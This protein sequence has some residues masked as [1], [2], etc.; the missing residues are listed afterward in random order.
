MITS[1]SKPTPDGDAPAIQMNED[2][3]VICTDSDPTLHR[4][5]TFSH[6]GTTQAPAITNSG[7]SF[8]SSMSVPGSLP[9]ASLRQQEHRRPRPH[10]R[11]PRPPLS[12]QVTPKVKMSLKDFAMKKKKQPEGELAR[13]VT[14]HV[15]LMTPTRV[16]ESEDCAASP[17]N[18][19]PLSDTTGPASS[20]TSATNGDGFLWCM[21]RMAPPPHSPSEDSKDI[22]AG[23]GMTMLHYALPT[24][25]CSFSLSSSS[26][27]SSFTTIVASTSAAPGP[28]RLPPSSTYCPG[29]SYVALSL[30][31]SDDYPISVVNK[32]ALKPQLIPAMTRFLLSGVNKLKNNK[33]ISTCPIAQQRRHEH[34]PR[35][36]G[37][38]PLIISDLTNQDLATEFE[39]RHELRAEGTGCFMQLMAW[40][41]PQLQMDPDKSSPFLPSQICT[42]VIEIAKVDPLRFM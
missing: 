13:V 16:H 24:H 28:H 18:G 41:P 37:D 42:G 31:P 2:K 36:P 22:K 3:E 40:D 10:H 4:L 33:S 20:S 26:S 11:R 5:T 29:S 9:D 8:T 17:V 27:S 34:Q 19:S 38:F 14:R 6:L 32:E 12:P 21:S 25:P 23:D 35:R 7:L 15:I 39:G 1:V 30:P